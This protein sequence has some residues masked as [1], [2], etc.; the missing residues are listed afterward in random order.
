[1]YNV[2][3]KRINNQSYMV[4]HLVEALAEFHDNYNELDSKYEDAIIQIE[5]LKRQLTTMTEAAAKW[6]EIYEAEKRNADIMEHHLIIGDD[7]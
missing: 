3:G 4:D 6:K 1:M 7:K 5:S 2:E